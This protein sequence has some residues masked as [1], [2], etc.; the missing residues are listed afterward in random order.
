MHNNNRQE[1]SNSNATVSSKPICKL[2]LDVHAADIMVVRQVDGSNPQRAQRF[3]AR[4][5]LA[6]VKEQIETGFEVISCYEAG[7]TGYWLHRELGAVGATNYVVC[8]S[9]LDSRGKG[10]SNDQTDALELLVRLDRY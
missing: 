2:G 6:W 10:V 5:L 8:P 4:R 3:E 9:K 1:Q 7:P